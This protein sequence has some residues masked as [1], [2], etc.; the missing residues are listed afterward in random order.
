MTMHDE[1]RQVNDNLYICA[2]YMSVTGGGM[3][4]GPFVLVGPP[5]KFS[6]EEALSQ[7]GFPPTKVG[8]GKV[9]DV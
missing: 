9:S 2:G 3:N 6:G 7:P 5:S 8:R 1:V 4:P